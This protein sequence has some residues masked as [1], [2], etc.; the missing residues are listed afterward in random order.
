[1]DKI[2]LSG[3]FY[4]ISKSNWKSDSLFIY[5]HIKNFCEKIDNEN[6]LKKRKET[7][8]KL[9]NEDKYRTI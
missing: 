9:L 5:E 3:P 7:I 8:N 4:S 1:M 6:K 2:I